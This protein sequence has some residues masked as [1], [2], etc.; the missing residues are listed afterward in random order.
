M[1]I[2]ISIT[3]EP[4]CGKTTVAKIVCEQ[5]GS[6]YTSTGSIQREIAANMGITTLDLNKLAETDPSIDEKIDSHT[7]ALAHSGRSVLVD[8]RLAWRFLPQS[9]KVFLVCPPSVA[10]SRVFDQNRANESYPTKEAAIAAL[11]ARYE[12]EKA[13][14][15]K[16]YGANLA[17]LRN[18]DLVIDTAVASP[19]QVAEVI[20]RAAKQHVSSIGSSAAALMVV[21]KTSLLDWSSRFA[22]HPWSQNLVGLPVARCQQNWG[23]LDA[24]NTARFTD[25]QTGLVR[26]SLQG[27]D[28]EV[29]RV[30][31]TARSLGGY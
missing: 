16:Y 25:P 18:Y 29:I 30:G 31:V 14:F 3:G 23:A 22:S 7:R 13:R 27:Q 24:L 15:A 28:D 2:Q 19:A 26:C 20:I 12:S 4:G 21:H 6:D 1:Q 8:S 10:A 5:L 17:N 11:I 9:L